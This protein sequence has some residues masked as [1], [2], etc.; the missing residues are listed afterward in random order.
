MA[1]YS[2]SQDWMDDDDHLAKAYLLQ[3]PLDDMPRGS[4]ASPT[5]WPCNCNDCARFK[6]AADQIDDVPWWTGDPV[7]ESIIHCMAHGLPC[8][9]ASVCDQ[10]HLFGQPCVHRWCRNSPTSKSECH[11]NECRYAHRDS[12]GTEK[13]DPRWIVLPGKLPSYLSKARIASRTFEYDGLIP[14]SK[15][16]TEATQLALDQRQKEGVNELRSGIAAGEGTMLTIRFSCSCQFESCD[17]EG[18]E[19]LELIFGQPLDRQTADH[20]LS[21]RLAYLNEFLPTPF[22]DENDTE[23]GHGDT[24]ED[25]HEEDLKGNTVHPCL[26]CA[27]RD[28]HYS[29][30]PCNHHTCIK[31]STTIFFSNWRKRS[32]ANTHL[33]QAANNVLHC[34]SSRRLRDANNESKE[35][36]VTLEVE[37]EFG[38]PTDNCSF[39]VTAGGQHLQYVPK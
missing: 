34:H 31:L 27:K 24:M 14:R 8:N 15:Q 26:R 38:S 23:D 1:T 2:S 13:N 25:E 17:G 4:H 28:E 11:N 22:D 3:S 20:Q 18:Q 37:I 30:A 12:V 29:V 36:V 16:E 7:C 6:R 33:Q 39:H 35:V 21:G 5:Y 32:S 19:S 9:E 10:C